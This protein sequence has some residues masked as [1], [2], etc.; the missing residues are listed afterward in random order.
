MNVV[1]LRVG[2]D[3]GCGGAQGPLFRDG[4]FEFICIPDRKQ[5]D[6]RKY[7][8]TLGRTERPLIDFFPVATRSKLA[9]QSIHVD[10]EFETLTYGDPTPPKAGLRRL[11]AGDL[12]VF[13]AGLQGFDFDAAPALYL[14]GYFE[15]TIA[16][17]ARDFD[18]AQINHNFGANFHVRHK[19]LYETQRDQLV[20]VKGGRGSRLLKKA[21]KLSHIGTDINGRPLKVLSDE[22]QQIFGHFGGRISIQRSPPRWVDE[23]HVQTAA[24]F[25]R[26]LK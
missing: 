14:V 12:L 1:L 3:S 25:V 23:S 4:S 5:L 7:G 22:M 21:V 18:P 24:R 6:R 15:V 2:I 11:K 19:S 10:P 13:Y 16:G 9:D 26:S 8:N 20:L 17:F